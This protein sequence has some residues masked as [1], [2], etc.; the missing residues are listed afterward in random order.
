METDMRWSADS[1]QVSLDDWLKES[2]FSDPARSTDDIQF[3][4]LIAPW[5][6]VRDGVE[7]AVLSRELLSEVTSAIPRYANLHG[8]RQ[9][10][11]ALPLKPTDHIRL[12]KPHY[13]LKAGMKREPPSLILMKND[14][15]Y[16][17][18][19]EEYYRRLELPTKGCSGVLCVYRSQRNFLG[20]TASSDFGNAIYLVVECPPQ[21]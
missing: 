7:L 2:A 13:W 6:R 15:F 11:V 1:Y 4:Y 20:V 18:Y 10:I 17:H 19:D 16:E 12:W 8:V 21:M 3:D 9:A 14:L 5:E